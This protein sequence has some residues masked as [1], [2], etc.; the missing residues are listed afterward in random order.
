MSYKLSYFN[1]MGLGE[2]IR[3]LL[4]Y[5]GIKFVDHRVMDRDAEW[6]QLKPSKVQHIN[7]SYFIQNFTNIVK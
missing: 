1:V 6:K 3:L 2:P 7:C 4:T 5:G